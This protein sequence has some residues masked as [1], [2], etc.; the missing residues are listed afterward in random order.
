M[1]T[2]SEKKTR[3][4]LCAAFAAILLL[5]ALSGCGRKASATEL[6]APVQSSEAAA[7]A[8][9]SE[10]EAVPGRQDGERFEDVIILEGMEETVRYEHVR[11]DA[12]GFEMDFDYE[13]FER[14][15]G[16]DRECFVSV[17]DAAEK[18]ENYLV[19][20]YDPRDA[21]AAAA[22]IGEAL[23][24]VYDISREDSF[25]LAH[26]GSCIRI[27]A[28]NGKG[29]TGTPDQL[30]MI[31]IVPAAD[32]G[33]IAAAHYSFESAEGFGRRFRYFMDS[34]SVLAAQGE[35][36]IS[37]EQALAAVRQYCFSIDPSLQSI[38]DAGE[39]PVYWDV[40]SAESAIVVLFRSYTGAQIRYY[41]DPLTGDTYATEFVPG[42]TPEEERTAE[43]LNVRDYTA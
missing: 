36:R 1:Y 5:T 19:V 7:Q 20:R 39:Y 27:D 8:A 34:F 37:E 12:V 29:N 4:K 17:W 6:S 10:P 14:H 43:S 31:Y 23:S 15:S 33:R 11:N 13:R 32:G 3:A 2:M 16:T 21:G 22:A 42:I 35:N 40:S 25:E 18:P 28:S 30:Q 41:V 9:P 24:S 26:A 38:A